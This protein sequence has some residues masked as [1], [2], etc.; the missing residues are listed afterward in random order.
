MRRLYAERA[1]VRLLALVVAVGPLVGV[2]LT[3]EVGARPRAASASTSVTPGWEPDPFSIGS[4]TFTDA[5]GAVVTTGSMN[6]PLA[7]Y[8]VGSKL[9]VPGDL[10]GSLQVFLPAKGVNPGLW[11]GEAIG[12]DTLFNPAPTAW[13]TNLKALVSAGLPVI[14]EKSGDLSAA[15]FSADFPN[16]STDPRYQNLYEIRM[17]TG[18]TS[19]TYD[20]ADILLNP[21]AGTWQVVYPAGVSSR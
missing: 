9:A 3:V 10:D 1:V 20:S 5:S 13:P 12:L 21:T 7:A 18:T 11:S 15:L 14:N 17:F 2:L 16:T 4:I 8:A 6:A 19:A